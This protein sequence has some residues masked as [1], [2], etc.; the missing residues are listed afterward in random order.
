[1][2]EREWKG[3]NEQVSEQV[4]KIASYCVRMYD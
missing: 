1:M 3:R 4:N 2:R